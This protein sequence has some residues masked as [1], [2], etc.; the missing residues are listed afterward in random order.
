MKSIAPVAIGLIAISLAACQTSSKSSS[1]STPVVQAAT[2]QEKQATIGRVK[3]LAGTWN[4]VND[5]GESHGQTVFAVGGGNTVREVMF[6]GTT[7]EMT[8]MYH[9]DGTSIVC[10]HYCAMGNQPRMKATGA[11]GETIVFK[12]DRVS[13]LRSADEEYMGEMWLTFKDPNTIQERWMSFKGDKVSSDMT[14]TLTRAQ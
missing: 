9:M 13:N 3:S 1:S 7:H 8:N 10:T 6:P 12:L 5:K 4:H 11:E 14:F 2:A